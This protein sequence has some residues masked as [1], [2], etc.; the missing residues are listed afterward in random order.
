MTTTIA[1]TDAETNFGG[2]LERVRAGD[3]FVIT[4]EGEALAELGPAKSKS[5]QVQ[6]S[7][8]DVLAAFRALRRQTKPATAAELREWMNEGRR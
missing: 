7:A 6:G 4:E 2:L 8:L 5:P 3:R 1:K